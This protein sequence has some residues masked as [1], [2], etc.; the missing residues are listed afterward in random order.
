MVRSWTLPRFII[1]IIKYII[2]KI[3]EAI[4]ASSSGDIISNRDWNLDENQENNK[5]F[6]QNDFIL[7]I[8]SNW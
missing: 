2:I 5:Q 7:L 1:G 8:K 3:I 4:Q 6:S